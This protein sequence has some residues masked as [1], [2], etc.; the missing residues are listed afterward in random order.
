MAE[1][2]KA[3]ADALADA[4]RSGVAEAD[5]TLDIEG[6]DAAGKLVILANAVLGMNAHLRDVERMGITGVTREDMAEASA[7]GER[8]KLLCRA[9]RQPTGSYALSV[10]PTPIPLSHPLAR[11]SGEALGI[12]YETDINGSVMVTISD[13]GPMGTAAAMLRDLVNVVGT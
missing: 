3:F 6:Y 11:L 2:G 9:E 4:Q 5:P 7:R 1:E 8:I 13:R 12:V 10:K